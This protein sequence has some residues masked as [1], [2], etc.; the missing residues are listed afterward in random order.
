MLYLKAMTLLSHVFVC[1]D[2]R[3]ASLHLAT[4]AFYTSTTVVLSGSSISH[5]PLFIPEETETFRRLWTLATHTPVDYR[6]WM[7]Y[8]SCSLHVKQDWILA[9]FGEYVLLWKHFKQ[10]PADFCSKFGNSYSDMFTQCRSS[11]RWRKLTWDFTTPWPSDIGWLKPQYSKPFYYTH[12][13][14]ME[15]VTV[16]IISSIFGGS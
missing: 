10:L 11:W 7:T 16:L 4:F 13:V 15:T 12:S 6:C 1:W 9:R 14:A 2:Y 5:L 8:S 3:S